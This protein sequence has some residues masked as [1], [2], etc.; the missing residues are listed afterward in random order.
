[1]SLCTLGRVK[2]E[3]CFSSFDPL[4]PFFAELDFIITYKLEETNKKL[5]DYI[6]KQ[7]KKLS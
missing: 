6:I 5:K 3:A 2:L 4:L 7:A 1:M